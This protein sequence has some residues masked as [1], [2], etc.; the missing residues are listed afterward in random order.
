M[1]RVPKHAAPPH[2]GEILLEEFL[3]PLE[4]SQAE[5][6]RR[7]DVSR[8]MVNEI[9]RGK[10]AVQLETAQKL[11]R[12]FQTSPDF[13]MSMQLRWDLYHAKE[14][15]EVRKVKPLDLAHV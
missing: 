10:R 12:L 8:R 3:E 4:I 15:P 1:V 7:L 5:L 13:W 6:A 9:V 2:P 14:T 11:G